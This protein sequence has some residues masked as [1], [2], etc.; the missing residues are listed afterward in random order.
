MKTIIA[1]SCSLQIDV[2]IVKFT[3]NDKKK[4][5]L[6]GWA[7][8]NKQ[9]QVKINNISYNYSISNSS[10]WPKDYA[11][12]DNVSIYQHESID[13]KK[14]HILMHFLQTINVLSTFLENP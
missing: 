10:S 12:A 2:K 6:R 4:Y 5:L 8:I 13:V 3:S 9:W 7:K 1:R 14:M 11:C